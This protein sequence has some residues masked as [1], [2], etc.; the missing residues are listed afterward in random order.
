MCTWVALFAFYDISITYQSIYI[1]TSWF[2]NFTNDVKYISIL[3]LFS[4]EVT[5]NLNML[6]PFVKHRIGG[7][8]QGSFVITK[9]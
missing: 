1:Y 6:S 5:V 9:Y 3:N 8:M 7:N 2:P 4:D